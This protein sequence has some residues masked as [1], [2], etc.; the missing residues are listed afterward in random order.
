MQWKTKKK[1]RKKQREDATKLKPHGTPKR[2]GAPGK[3]SPC[4][5]LPPLGGA[6]G[7]WRSQV[8]DDARAPHAFFVFLPREGAAQGLA[9][10]VNFSILEKATQIVL[11]IFLEMPSV[12]NRE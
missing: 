1:K 7:Q 4:S 9:P 6:A 5:P 11:E 8:T 2:L 10:L 3:N 12:L